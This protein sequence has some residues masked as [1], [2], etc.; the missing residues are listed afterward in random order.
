MPATE[1]DWDTPFTINRFRGGGEDSDSTLPVAHTCF[2]SLDLPNWSSYEVTRER[3][4]FA[5]VN[6]RAIDTDFNPN[7]SAWVDVETDE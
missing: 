2:F 6:C 5:I 4:L 7:S 3:I 1:S